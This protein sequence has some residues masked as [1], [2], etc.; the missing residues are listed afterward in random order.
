[1]L[2]HEIRIRIWSGGGHT[3][4]ERGH[5]ESQ[6]VIAY[7]AVP[8]MPAAAR[9]DSS[10]TKKRSA[11]C[12]PLRFSLCVLCCLVVCWFGPLCSSLLGLG[13][14][15]RVIYSTLH[16][17]IGFFWT[18]GDC[19][20]SSGKACSSSFIKSE[21]SCLDSLV[22]SVSWILRNIISQPLVLSVSNSLNV[23]SSL[24]LQSPVLLFLTH[25][26]PYWFCMYVKYCVGWESIKLE[27]E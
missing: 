22:F 11:S 24:S 6:A 15:K 12:L 10:E 16:V 25:W 23:T 18:E 8:K 7:H 13:P 20:L 21:D 17:Y 27:I 14:R 2:C 1:M 26:L 3:E 9:Y 4:S 19:R 5:L